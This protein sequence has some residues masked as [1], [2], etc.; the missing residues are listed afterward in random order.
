MKQSFGIDLLADK[1]NVIES[2]INN[3]FVEVKNGHLR[4]TLVGMAVA[5]SMVLV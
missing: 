4:P 1:K 5:D 3:Q 2:L